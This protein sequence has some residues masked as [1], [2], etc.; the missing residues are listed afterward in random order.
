[1]NLSIQNKSKEI[2]FF[3]CLFI[4]L[5]TMGCG[6]WTASLRAQP[7]DLVDVPTAEVVDANHYSANFRLYREG[8][9]LSRIGFGLGRRV[10]L[11]ISFDIVNFIGKEKVDLQRPELQMKYRFYDG[12]KQM[13][14]FALGYDSQGYYYDEVTK[15]YRYPQKGVYVVASREI[16]PSSEFH[17]GLNVYDFESDRFFGFFGFS[18]MPTEELIVLA[19]VDS[20]YRLQGGKRINIGFRYLHTPNLS[21]EVSARDLSRNIGSERIVKINYQGKL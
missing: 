4:G 18:Y 15:K 10:N 14:A 16:F 5:W 7:I 6:L 1:M 20:I 11:G 13:P 12:S 8:G 9:I 19:E 2:I 3:I 21:I 17:L